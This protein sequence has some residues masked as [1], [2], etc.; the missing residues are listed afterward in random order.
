M[1]YSISEIVRSIDIS[2]STLSC[3]YREKSLPSTVDIAVADH[4]FLMIVFRGAWL[5]LSATTDPGSNRIHIY[6]VSNRSVVPP[7]A[8]IIPNKGP[9]LT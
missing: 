5:E 4:R 2:Q 6:H 8:S 9:H 3:V 7:L 1:R